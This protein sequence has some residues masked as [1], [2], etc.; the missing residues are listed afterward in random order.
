MIRTIILTLILIMIATIP[1]FA[2]TSKY[3]PETERLMREA[4]LQVDE[5]EWEEIDRRQQEYQKR[6]QNSKSS[7]DELHI[8]GN[9]SGSV[10]VTDTSDELHIYSNE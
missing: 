9:N 2:G 5:L 3:S 1:A 10:A 6:K 7:N 4:G 8:R